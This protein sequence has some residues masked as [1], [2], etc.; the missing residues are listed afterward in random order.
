MAAVAH[1]DGRG[2]LAVAGADHGVR[3][4][5]GGPGGGEVEVDHLAE[6]VD[7]AV[8]ASRAGQGDR[9]A[10]DAGQRRAEGIGHG[11]LTLLGRESVESRAVV[12]DGQP[13][14]DG[15]VIHPPG[16]GGRAHTNSMRAIGALSPS[17]LPSLRIRV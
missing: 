14:P 12:G 4:E 2:Q 3:I 16:P 10:G 13:P 11:A 5:T 7:A 17:R 1:D 15:L 6:G 9:G 8:G